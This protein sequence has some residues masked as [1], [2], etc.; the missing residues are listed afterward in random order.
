MQ[1]HEDVWSSEV[2][3]FHL[4]YYLITLAAMTELQLIKVYI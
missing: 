1:N 2:L 3:H 4:S